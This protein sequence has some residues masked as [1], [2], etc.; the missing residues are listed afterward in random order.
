MGIYEITDTEDVKAYDISV[1]N[2][3]ELREVVTSD[4]LPLAIKKYIAKLALRGRILTVVNIQLESLEAIDLI[5]K[6]FA[7]DE[8]EKLDDVKMR[9]L[10]K[11]E[12]RVT[13]LRKELQE[14]MKGLKDNE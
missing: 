12:K 4:E 7:L 9:S 3:E 11:L 1:S 8:E 5:E 14:I 10:K 2:P 13:K 6:F